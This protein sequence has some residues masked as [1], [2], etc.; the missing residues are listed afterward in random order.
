MSQYA[1]IDY[2]IDNLCNIISIENGIGIPALKHKL[3]VIYLEDY[4]QFM[5]V[6]T[7]V[8]EPDYIDKDYLEDYA[9]YYV[10]SFNAYKRTCLRL[11]FFSKG[12]DRDVFNPI[13]TNT[14]EVDL[15]N[16]Y[17]GFIVIKPLPQTIFGRTC[18]R[19]YPNAGCRYFNFIRPYYVN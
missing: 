4:F 3:H 11:H 10:R 9:A 13:L 19:T 16:D 1:V 17:I 8:L 6:K 2:S 14:S 18:L 5:G 7:I 12:F 15:S